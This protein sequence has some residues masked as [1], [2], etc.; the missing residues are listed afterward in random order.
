MSNDILVHYG[1]PRRSGRYPWGSGEHPFQSRESFTGYLKTLREQGL[2]EK[3][4]AYAVGLTTEQLRIQE[5]VANNEQRNID[6]ARA[7]DLRY[8][9]GYSLQKVTEMMSDR[10]Y[11]SDSSI[12]ALLDIDVEGRKNAARGASNFLKEQVDKYGMVDV[13]SGVESYLNITKKQMDEALF[14][15]DQSGYLIYK[16]QVPQPTN[17]GRKTTMQ[18]LCKPDTPYKQTYNFGDIHEVDGVISRD[19]G[20]TFQKAF[21]YPASM[22]S[23]R[24]AICYKEDGGDQ[25]D[26]LVEIRPGVEDLSL[27]NSKYAQVRILVDD[28]HYIKGMAVYNPD[29]PE[30]IDVRFNTSKSNSKS[31]MEVLK[32]ID[33]KDPDNP[34]GS[35]LKEHGGQST[36]ID[37]NGEEKLSLINKRADEGDWGDWTDSVPSQFLAKQEL[38]LINRQLKLSEDQKLAEFKELQTITNPTVKKQLLETFASDCDST[39]VHL[40]AASLPRQ[41]YKVILPV[42]DLKDTEVYAPGYKDGETL[43]LVRFPHGGTFEIPIVTVTTKNAAAKKM[44]GNTPRDAIGINATVAAKLSG[45]DFDG[46][47]VMVIPTSRSSLKMDGKG[48]HPLKPNEIRINARPSLKG[49]ENF[50]PKMEYPEREGMKYLQKGPATQRQMGE[51][52]N[53][54]TDMTLKGAPDEDLAKAVRHSMVVIDA[55]KHKLNYKQSEIDNDIKALKDYYQGRVENGKYTTS[56]ATLISRAKAET[57]INKRIGSPKIDPETGEEIWKDAPLGKDFETGLKTYQRT[58][59]ISQMMKVK[60]A[61]ELSS[62]TIKEEAYAD[63]ANYMKQLANQARLEILKTGNIEYSK[64]AHARYKDEVDAL[65]AWLR[66]V[67]Q[68]KPRERRAAAIANAAVAEKKAAHPDMTKKELGKQNQIEMVRARAITGAKR[69]EIPI[70]DRT[71]EAIQ[72][73]AIT[74]TTLRRVLA[75]TDIDKLRDRALPH[76]KNELSATQLNLLRTMDAKGY[77]TLDIAKR[78]DVSTSTIERYLKE[79]A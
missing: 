25:K 46:D 55:A 13:S 58:Q 37:K 53:L 56:A 22:D 42:T 77:S 40:Q 23:K 59:K 41:A 78:L 47:T 38:E 70:S 17:P 7:K 24:L 2:N 14:M 66:M 68:N 6:V 44:L 9:K 69:V 15:L 12:R 27:G 63:Y 43:A 45:A 76:A 73:G 48:K 39:A 26:G 74:E 31:M 60:D 11:K 28:T 32:P 67:D 72:A 34:F 20:K 54:I 52:S 5:A 33:I 75:A 1:M 16:N 51:I 19:G 62:G 18:I 3:E 4:V 64:E 8:N 65:D 50:D 79:G 10:G 29:L 49:L 35:L 21:R 57:S 71:W 61:H 36:Y 30:G